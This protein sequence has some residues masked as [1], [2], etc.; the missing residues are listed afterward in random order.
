VST[1][2]GW[3]W[4]EKAGAWAEFSIMSQGMSKSEAT[5]IED[6]IVRIVANRATP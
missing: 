3:V 6:R 5:A 2:S 1:L 4:L